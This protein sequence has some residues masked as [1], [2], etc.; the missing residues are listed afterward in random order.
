MGNFFNNII[1]RNNKN[2][3]KNI[4]YFAYNIIH[5]IFIV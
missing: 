2:T 3:S 1:Q 5:L 4:N